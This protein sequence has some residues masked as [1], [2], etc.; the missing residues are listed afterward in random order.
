[1]R[2]PNAWNAEGHRAANHYRHLW[3]IFTKYNG[4][5]NGSVVRRAGFGLAFLPRQSESG[6]RFAGLEEK[7]YF[8]ARRL[9]QRAA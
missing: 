4:N 6:Q 9:K 5:A 8:D 1:M 2:Y 3:H 7:T